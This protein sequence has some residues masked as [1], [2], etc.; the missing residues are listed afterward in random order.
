MPL[1]PCEPA[2]AEPALGEPMAL[3]LLL[4]P[5]DDPPE[6]CASEVAGNIKI[7]IAATAAADTR[8]MGISFSKQREPRG[9]CSGGT[10]P[11]PDHSFT[12]A[13]RPE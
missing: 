12:S 3:P 7:V 13:R 8:F 10:N 9:S 11:L 6:L 4:P 5:A 1:M 2:P